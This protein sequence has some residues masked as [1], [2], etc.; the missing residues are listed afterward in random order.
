MI[1]IQVIKYPE[2][3][4]GKMVHAVSIV[5]DADNVRLMLGASSS[6]EAANACVLEIYNAVNKAQGLKTAGAYV[7]AND[8]RLVGSVSDVIFLNNRVA[9]LK[10]QVTGLQNAVTNNDQI[11]KKWKRYAFMFAAIA[12]ANFFIGQLMHIRI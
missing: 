6:E 12:M 7:A 3:E 10:A 8:A 2:V 9:E 11:G 4:N 1:R 5:N